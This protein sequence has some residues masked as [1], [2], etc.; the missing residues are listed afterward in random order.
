MGRQK[1]GCLG[2]S[3]KGNGIWRSTEDR[4]VKHADFGVFL[5]G[6]IIKDSA[7][8]FCGFTIFIKS[9]TFLCISTLPPV[10]NLI[11]N[12]LSLKQQ[13]QTFLFRFG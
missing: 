12:V 4:K 3:D 10:E 9:R 8:F 1:S 2:T 6:P 7:S 13:Q 5:V 11:T